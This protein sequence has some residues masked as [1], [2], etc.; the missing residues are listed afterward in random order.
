MRIR[1]LEEGTGFRQHYFHASEPGGSSVR[2]RRMTLKRVQA[3][4]SAP[5]NRIA[6]GCWRS[7]KSVGRREY[8]NVI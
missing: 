1:E 5:T 2:P 8:R 3:D 6:A 4:T 7:L